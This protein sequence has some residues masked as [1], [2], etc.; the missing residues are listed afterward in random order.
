LAPGL[1][2]GLRLYP[3]ADWARR[4]S[5]ME[6]LPNL[7]YEAK[8]MIQ[9]MR[10]NAIEVAI[11]PEREILIPL[12]LRQ[13]GRLKEQVLV[14]SGRDHVEIWNPDTWIRHDQPVD[15]VAHGVA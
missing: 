15:A 10:S 14:V 7:R 6:A 11:G 3:A 2:H 4:L 1:Q 8:L 13:L 5:A 9:L 12:F